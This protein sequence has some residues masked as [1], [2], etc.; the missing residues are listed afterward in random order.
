MNQKEVEDR[1]WKNIIGFFT[2][3]GAVLTLILA[4]LVGVVVYGWVDD[5]EGNIE[6]SLLPFVTAVIVTLPFLTIC[7]HLYGKLIIIPV[8]NKIGSLETVEKTPEREG[9]IKIT[10]RKAAIQ[11]LFDVSDKFDEQSRQYAERERL[12]LS[13]LLEDDDE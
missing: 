13:Y 3:L 4:V 6:G 5:W 2:W 12:S 1:R 7:A 10:D 8:E 11:K 9:W